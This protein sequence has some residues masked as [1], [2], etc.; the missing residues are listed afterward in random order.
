MKKFIF[1]WYFITQNLIQKYFKMYDSLCQSYQPFIFVEDKIKS[2]HFYDLLKS[3]ILS[4]L[5]GASDSYKRLYQIVS[6]LDDTINF[7]IS[8][9]NLWTNNSYFMITILNNKDQSNGMKCSNVDYIPAISCYETYA[10]LLQ[11]V[12]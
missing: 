11:Y 4:M 10:L 8:T 2:Q 3:W 7:I 6:D 9:N 1:K 12:S 5:P